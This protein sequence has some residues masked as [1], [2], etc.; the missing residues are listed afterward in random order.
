[1]THVSTNNLATRYPSPSHRST[2]QSMTAYLLNCHTLQGCILNCLLWS[3][4]NRQPAA[5]VTQVV[6]GCIAVPGLLGASD[7]PTRGFH[8]GLSTGQNISFT[9]LSIDAIALEQYSL[10][11]GKSA[12]QRLRRIGACKTPRTYRTAILSHGFLEKSG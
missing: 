6:S 7:C 12:P 10:R 1:M 2:V 5:L 3:M 4:R 9:C 11:T 8:L